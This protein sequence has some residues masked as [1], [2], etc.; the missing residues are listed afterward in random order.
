MS[1][2]ERYR[3]Y[4]LDCLGLANKTNDFS[5][6][7]LLVDMAQAW[8]KLAEQAAKNADA[9]A[10]YETPTPSQEQPRT[11]ADDRNTGTLASKIG[12]A[13]PGKHNDRGFQLLARRTGG[14]LTHKNRRIVEA[15]KPGC[16][17]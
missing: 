15:A 7:T 9:G 4:A 14:I 1:T 16:S 10:V 8:V 17:G 12:G 5:T 2:Y 11:K 13:P 3:L 6:K